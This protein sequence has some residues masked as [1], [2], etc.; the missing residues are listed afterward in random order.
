MR[1]TMRKWLDY[2]G[3]EWR[4]E[5]QSVVLILTRQEKVFWDRQSKENTGE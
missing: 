2:K 4:L 5:N 1:G 3:E